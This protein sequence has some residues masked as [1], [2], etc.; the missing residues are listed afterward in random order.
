MQGWKGGEIQ[1]EFTEMGGKRNVHKEEA[2]WN[3]KTAGGKQ[4]GIK[5]RPDTTTEERSTAAEGAPQGRG[6]AQG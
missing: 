6:H 1:A 4:C 5:E 2:K 3:E